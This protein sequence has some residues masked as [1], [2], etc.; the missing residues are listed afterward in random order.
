MVGGDEECSV[1][2]GGGKGYSVMEGSVEG[3]QRGGGGYSV[4]V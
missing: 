3:I 4:L 2:V 1:T